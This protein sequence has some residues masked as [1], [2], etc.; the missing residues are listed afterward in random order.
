MS[1]DLAYYSMPRRD[2]VELIPEQVNRALEIGCGVG[3]TLLM[4]KKGLHLYPLIIHSRSYE[5]VIH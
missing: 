2:I 3:N 4:L 5:K 1:D